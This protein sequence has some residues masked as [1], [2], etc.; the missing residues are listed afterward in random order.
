MFQSAKRIK[1]RKDTITCLTEAVEELRLSR[2]QNLD[3]SRAYPNTMAYLNADRYAI[4]TSMEPGIHGPDSVQG[5]AAMVEDAVRR[6]GVGTAAGPRETLECWSCRKPGHMKK[7][8]RSKNNIIC[9][10]CK[11]SGHSLENCWL[12]DKSKR[13]PRYGGP[14]PEPGQVNAMELMEPHQEV[15][16]PEAPVFPWGQSM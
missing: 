12:K 15:W 7:D 6:L 1:T 3:P 13:P 11:K 10:Y 2:E 14:A 5:I 8:C 4:Q 16:R 9:T